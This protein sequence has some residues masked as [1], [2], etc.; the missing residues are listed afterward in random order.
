MAQAC[1]EACWQSWQPELSG[2]VHAGSRELPP[3]VVLWPQHM[4]TH[5]K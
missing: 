5:K 4:H 2:H 1:K 3:I